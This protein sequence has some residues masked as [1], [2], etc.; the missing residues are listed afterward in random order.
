MA[1]LLA[2]FAAICLAACTLTP[3]ASTDTAPQSIAAAPTEAVA[4]SAV[5]ILTQEPCSPTDQDRYVYNP[6]RLSVLAGCIRVSGTVAI[7]RHEADGDLH[8]L[9]AVDPA[10]RDLL[11]PSNAGEEL[12]DLVVEPV[13]VRAVTQADAKATCSKDHDPL[14]TLPSVGTH[15][16]ME[17]RYVLDT[18]HGNW[19][20]LHPLYRW[21]T[22][23]AVAPPPT[24]PPTPSPDTGT[25]TPV[26]TPIDTP[27]A[28]EPPPLAIRLFVTTPV[29]RNTNATLSARTHAGAQ[30]GIEVDYKSGP[31]HAA[32]LV[33]K[34][35]PSS[36]RVTW[37][38]KVGGRT[39]RGTWPIVVSCTWNDQSGQ[40]TTSFTVR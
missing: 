5:P 28:T 23:D 21:G 33:D 30:C 38:W 10:F 7:I 34:T 6:S 14:T 13:C 19:A 3:I 17:G 35:V 27:P 20:E 26:P 4:A 36:G 12:G 40:S 39:T 11:R 9:L 22:D 24:Q 32:G 1:R 25:P 18:E 16:W 2:L 8:V 29:S 37:T 31:S 15:V